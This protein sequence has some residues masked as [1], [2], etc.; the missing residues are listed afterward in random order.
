M[1]SLGKIIRKEVKELLTPATLIPIIIIAILFGS[2]GG[3]F[4]GVEEQLEEP[5]MIAV[6]NE[7][8]GSLSLVA[9]AVFNATSDIVYN[10]TDVQEA[11]NVLDEKGGVSLFVIPSN[12][13][14]DIENDTRGTIEIF[15]IMK[16]AGIMDSVPGAAADAN[17][18]YVD[19][20]ISA[21]LINGN[22]S[23][24]A[25]L[26][27]N[28][29]QYYE[30]TLF[31]G[32]EMTG[33]SPPT[34]ASV[35]SSQSFVMPLIVMM[36][37]IYAGSI[38]ISSMGSEKE[39]KTLETLLTMPVSRTSIVF[40]KLIG[41][42]LVGLLMAVI[43]M[44]GMS[45]YFDSLMGSTSIDLA[46]FGLTLS[47][48]DYVLVGMSLFASLV[49]ALALCMILGIFTKNYKAA[50]T[51]TM[52]VTFLAMIPMFVTMFT[53]VDTLP[54]MVKVLVLAIPFSHPMIAM[55]SLM[56]DDYAL[57]LGGIAYTS[58]VALL[59]MF[60]A[61]TLFKKDILLTGKVSSSDKKSRYPIIAL[62]QTIA[63][64]RKK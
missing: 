32:K 30:T 61:V 19:Q 22:M 15:W 6:I 42:A 27:L 35:M 23:Q 29:T 49:F 17:L 63:R 45:Y 62:L 53:D 51:M 44:F 20:A 57:V 9:M 4:G 60:V 48:L 52:P 47:I 5:P 55:R 3:V 18:M 58:A 10:G 1:S 14:S 24:N 13:T 34:I 25:S 43:Y 46:E 7:D 2:L 16:G 21:A 28:P 50:Q 56:F 26:I 41:A 31:K 40:G 11:L 33:I 8:G 37:I 39:N 36:V 38:V 59:A 64:K 54:M 12:F